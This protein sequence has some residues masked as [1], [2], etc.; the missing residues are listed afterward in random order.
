MKAMAA[1]AYF[2]MDV[3]ASVHAMSDIAI[4][5]NDGRLDVWDRHCKQRSVDCVD[6]MLQ[7][8]M[9][10]ITSMAYYSHS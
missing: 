6:C 5:G 1:M 2:S 10:F 7:R 9:H 4:Q 8:D 3:T